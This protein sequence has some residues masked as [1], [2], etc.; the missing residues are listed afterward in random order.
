VRV[1]YFPAHL[2]RATVI[3]ALL[4]PKP[5][6]PSALGDF[7]YPTASAGRAI[8]VVFGTVKISGGK[9]RYGGAICTRNRS[10]RIS[11]VFSPAPDPSVTSI[12][13]ACSTSSVK[14]RSTISSVM[15]ADSK[16]LDYSRAGDGS[17]HHVRIG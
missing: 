11:L 15:E 16:G 4:R 8:P 2:R 12:F 7:G 1:F 14:G 9:Y 3:S 17:D 10:R 6:G 13:S 5:L